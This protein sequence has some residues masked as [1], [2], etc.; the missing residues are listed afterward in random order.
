MRSPRNAGG[1]V[2]RIEPKRTG[3][4]RRDVGMGSTLS[5]LTGPASAVWSIV[6][7]GQRVEHLSAGRRLGTHLAFLA[8]HA[9]MSVI[10][11]SWAAMI[12]V[13]SLRT[14]SSLP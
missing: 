1:G 10:S 4:E 13:A 6:R 12:S 9:F 7:S 8:S 5:G 14:T 2:A 11:A 3:A